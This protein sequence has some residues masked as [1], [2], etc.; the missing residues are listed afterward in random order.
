MKREGYPNSTCYFAV[1]T[2]K[3]LDRHCNIM[4]PESVKRFLA[5]CSWSEGG[6]QRVAEKVDRFHRYGRL[7][8]D[9]TR[10]EKLDMLPHIP[11][12]E[13]NPIV[14][15]V[16]SS[17]IGTFVMLPMETGCSPG[18]ACMVEWAHIDHSRNTIVIR[19]EK[20]FRN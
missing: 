12:E 5:N 9:R 13:A 10:Y 15:G 2:L 20:G 6:K 3:R 18:E 14:S 11:T 8:W 1:R 7:S 4:E 17:A 19:A 16:S